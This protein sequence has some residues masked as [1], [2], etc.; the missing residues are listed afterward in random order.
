MPTYAPAPPFT[1]EISKHVSL[2]YGYKDA[3]VEVGI[4]FGLTKWLRFEAEEIVLAEKAFVEAKRWK[5]MPEDV[6][7]RMGA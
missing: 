1:V 5:E 2:R 3:H 4:T 6:R 7:T